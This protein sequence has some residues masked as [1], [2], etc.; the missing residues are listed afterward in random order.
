MPKEVALSLPKITVYSDNQ[1]VV[2]NYS[3]LMEYTDE[4]IRLKTSGKTITVSGTGL[5]LRT[6]T[7]IDVLIEGAINGVQLT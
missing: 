5:E 1:V 2:E 3:G 4:V 6:V 7:D